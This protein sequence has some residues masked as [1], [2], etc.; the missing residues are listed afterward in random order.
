MISVLFIC[1]ENADAGSGRSPER[2]CGFPWGVAVEWAAGRS[3][4]GPG[5][6]AVAT[7]R[8]EGFGS[9][10]RLQVGDTHQD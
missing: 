8:G 1:T 2:S 4:A 3:E 6:V 10:G 7:G 9:T 5:A